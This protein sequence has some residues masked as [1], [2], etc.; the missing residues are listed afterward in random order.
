[1]SSFGIS[2]SWSGYYI[3][4]LPSRDNTQNPRQ[5]DA[6]DLDAKLKPVCVPPSL[7]RRMAL[8]KIGSGRTETLKLVSVN[9]NLILV[10]CKPFFFLCPFILL[11]WPAL[12][13]DPDGPLISYQLAVVYLFFQELSA[14]GWLKRASWIGTVST[15]QF[16]FRFSIVLPRTQVIEQDDARGAK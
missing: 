15:S 3:K 2:C 14:R 10:K 12:K 5:I 6:V 16:Q 4:S 9:Y 8:V 11:R 13:A 1:M 7:L